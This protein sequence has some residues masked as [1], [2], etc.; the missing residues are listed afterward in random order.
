M[1]INVVDIDELQEFISDQYTK[2]DTLSKVANRILK[3]FIHIN[4]LYH[5]F[6]FK[7]YKILIK[8]YELDTYLNSIYDEEIEPSIRL[9]RYAIK[10]TETRKDINT[11]EVIILYEY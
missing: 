5:D 6:K 4:G 8:S 10:Y 7:D 2:H 1:K 3:D 11:K 9:L